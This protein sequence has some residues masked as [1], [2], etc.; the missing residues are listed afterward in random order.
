MM[1]TDSAVWP[2]PETRG[3]SRAGSSEGRT[4]ALNGVLCRG[5]L[6]APPGERTSW[7]SNHDHGLVLM[8]E[9]I[10]TEHV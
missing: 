2:T 6:S 4:T 5:G 7:P 1:W 10:K 3:L 8:G 9:G